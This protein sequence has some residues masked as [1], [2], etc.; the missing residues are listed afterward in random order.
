MSRRNA[1]EGST[2]PPG[3]EEKS[4]AQNSHGQ[5]RVRST[6]IMHTLPA[7]L[8]L[9]SER[10]RA[11]RSYFFT[12]YN[13]L[14]PC[15]SCIV[16]CLIRRAGR[17]LLETS[18][19]VE[20]RMSLC[21]SREQRIIVRNCQWSMARCESQLGVTLDHR[22]RTRCRSSSTLSGSKGNEHFHRASFTLARLCTL[23]TCLDPGLNEQLLLAC[24]IAPLR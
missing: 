21:F 12:N 24:R 1:R 9:F 20:L 6:Y 15:S 11:R 5:R 23:V 13:P 22:S 14:Q 7:G 2:P 4:S 19:D 10:R 8:F 17:K 18:V 16:Q 3:A